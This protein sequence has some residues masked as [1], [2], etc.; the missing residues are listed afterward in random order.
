MSHK[1][2]PSYQL[3]YLGI[4]R[5][6]Q[7]KR[8]WRYPVLVWY[9][10]QHYQQTNKDKINLTIDCHRLPSRCAIPFDKMYFIATFLLHF[11]PFFYFFVFHGYISNDGWPF[12]R[13]FLINV[14]SPNRWKGSRGAFTH[15]LSFEEFT[16]CHPTMLKAL[17]S[18]MPRRTGE[19]SLHLLI[20]QM[21]LPCRS[22]PKI[23]ATG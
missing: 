4:T 7:T 15:Y 23:S 18:Q 13:N 1:I 12:K 16:A 3:K 2:A 21:K 10:W 5:L 11:L 22:K 8:V 17:N 6:K 19:M 9:C 14:R 20:N